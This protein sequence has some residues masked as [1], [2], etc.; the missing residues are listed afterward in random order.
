MYG[1]S[2]AFKGVVYFLFKKYQM[3]ARPPR[4]P[5]PKVVQEEPEED[6][7]DDM[8][9]EYDG[10]E[11]VD[12][13]DALGQLLTTEEGETMAD[14]AKRQADATEK[15]ALQLEMQNKLLV[16]IVS[17]LTKHAPAPESA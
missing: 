17:A 10:E 7:E 1:K 9:E 3:S 5:P 2:F 12:M 4:P 11:G 15:V 8:M 13:F 16:K 6:D 14:L